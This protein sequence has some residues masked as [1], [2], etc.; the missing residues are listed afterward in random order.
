MIKV[1]AGEIAVWEVNRNLG[2]HCG[3]YFYAIHIKR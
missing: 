2:G 3:V 1:A